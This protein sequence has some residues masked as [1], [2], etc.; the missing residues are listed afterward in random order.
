[1][2]PWAAAQTA[3]PRWA[4]RL[5]STETSA[6]APRTMM[7][8]CVPMCRVTK[9]PGR[10]I[11]LSWPTNTHPRVKIFSISSAKMRGSV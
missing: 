9:S 4:H 1:M 7:T 6:L 11:S 5:S 10:G 3:V 2:L 8:G